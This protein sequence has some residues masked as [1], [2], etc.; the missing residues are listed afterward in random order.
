MTRKSHV[1][2]DE[3]LATDLK[4]FRN[5]CHDQALKAELEFNEINLYFQEV[6]K[7]LWLFGAFSPITG[8]SF[9][10]EIPHCNSINFQHFLNEFSKERPNQYKIM[11]LDNGAFRKAKTLEIPK[12]HRTYIF[13]TI[14]S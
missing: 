13:T 9:V 4:N 12:K 10:L 14:Q 11:V 3:I 8:D 2:K 7:N 5:K 1:K 6:F